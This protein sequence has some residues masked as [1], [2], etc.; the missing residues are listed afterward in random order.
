MENKPNPTLVYSS[1]ALSF[2]GIL[3]I[4][5]RE[6]IQAFISFGCTF[7]SVLWHS[8]KP[9][10]NWIL[11]ADMLFANSTALLAVHTA[12]RGSALALIPSSFFVGS[13][14]V[15]YYYGQHKNCF[16]WSPDYNTST[17]WHAVLHIGNGIMGAWLVLLITKN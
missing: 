16:L 4:Q 15:L 9:R 14:L 12:L 17:R 6:Y 3:F 10:Y 7:F 8:T 11:L 2:P 5:R 13:G 1:L